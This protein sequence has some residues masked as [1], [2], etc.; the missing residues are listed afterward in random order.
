MRLL[1]THTRH[2]RLVAGH[3]TLE[4]FD[5]AN[6]AAGLAFFK[7]EVEAVDAVVA[8]VLF[9]RL[10]LWIEHG[11]TPL[12]AAL[13]SIEQRERLVMQATGIEREHFDLRCMRRHDVREHH[14]FRTEAVRIDDILVLLH[15]VLELRAGLLHEGL[16]TW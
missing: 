3:C 4:G 14:R 15:G 10:R 6:R 5:L 7:A 11:D 1:A 9:D 13:E 16:Q 12:I 2:P 8:N